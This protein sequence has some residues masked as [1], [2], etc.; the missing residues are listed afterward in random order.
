V[1]LYDSTLIT[2]TTGLMIW[3]LVTFV[4][5]L[6][7]LRRYAF[8][9]IQQ[10]IDA[11]RQAIVA[12]L[13][14]AESARTE[15]QTAL[16]EY[17][18]QLA[19]ARREASK[20]VDD[21]RRVG[22]ER[23]TAAVADLEAEKARLMKQT[24]EEIRAETRQ[25]LEAIK[26]QVADLALSATE[27]VVRARLDEAEQRRLIDQALADVDLSTLVPPERAGEGK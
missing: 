21:A 17:R 11:R 26:H 18:Q 19:E 4:I 15:A 24:Q 25:A 10:M 20:I 14:A 13:D 9:P 22:D 2:P 27:K 5:V 8:G 12:D 6:I 7:V 23:R 1:I 16:A 3:T